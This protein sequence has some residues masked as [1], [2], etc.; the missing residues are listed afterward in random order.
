MYDTVI[1]STSHHI[2]LVIKRDID[3]IVD[4][5]SSFGLQLNDGKC[6]VMRFARKKSSIERLDMA[7]FGSYYVRGMSLPFADS[8]N[9]LSM[10]V[11]SE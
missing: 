11:D 1:L 9:D 3:T 7:Q 8:C 6:C 2:Y 5:A 4:V 10:L